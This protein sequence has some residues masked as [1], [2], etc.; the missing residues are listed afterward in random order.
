MAILTSTSTGGNLSSGS[1]WVGGVAPTTG[2]QVV[3]VNGATITVDVSISLGVNA[4][5][6]GHAVE[7]NGA[8][9]TSYGTLVVASGVT[10]TLLG[11]DLGSNT[12]GLVH[13]Y[14]KLTVQ[15]G[16]TIACDPNSDF[17]S[18]L[19]CNGILSA[20]GTSGS[21]CTFTSPATSY[22][23]ANS[24]SGEVYSANW[25]Y[26][27]LTQNLGIR[28]LNRAWIANA[29]GTGLGS[30]GDS[31]LSITSKTGT[32]ASTFTTEVS[33]L[34][35]VTGAGQYFVDY[36]TGVVYF[37]NAACSTTTTGF[38][39]TYKYLT[40]SKGWGIICNSNTDYCSAD[41]EYCDL[42]YMG[43]PNPGGSG[44]Y[45]VANGKLEPAAAIIFHY[46]NSATSAPNRLA[47]V[48]NCT[49]HYCSNGIGVAGCT[50]T[51]GDPI[52][53]E[54]NTFGHLDTQNAQTAG[55]ASQYG[56]ILV[57]GVVDASSYVH[58]INNTG[59]QGYGPVV[60]VRQPDT[61]CLI[62]GNTIQTNLCY[63]S[64]SSTPWSDCTISNNTFNFFGFNLR[65]DLQNNFEPCG[66]SGH[67]IVI[68]NNTYNRPYRWMYVGDYCTID[69]NV[70][71]QYSHHG[72]IAGQAYRVLTGVTVQNNLLVSNAAAGSTGLMCGYNAVLA[73]DGWIV[74][75]NT[76]SGPTGYPAY[77]FGDAADGSVSL[78][79]RCEY[80]NNLAIN[81]QTYYYQRSTDSAAPNRRTV[82]HLLECDNN[83]FHGS[84]T[85]SNFHQGA[86][87]YQSGQKYNFNGSRAI[88]GAAL[89]NPSYTSPPAAQSLVFTYTSSTN[90][91]L[92]WGGGTAAQLYYDGGTVSSS[93][94]NYGGA[95]YPYAALTVSGTS[96]TWSTDRTSANNPI[97]CWLYFGSGPMATAGWGGTGWFRVI[98]CTSSTA[99]SLVPN[100]T[101]LPNAGDAFTLYKGEVAL[102]DSGGTNGVNVGLYWPSMPGSSQTDSGI[103]YTTS[104]LIGTDP[105]LPNGTNYDDAT[106]ADYRPPGTSAAKGA[107]TSTNAPALDFFGTTRPSPPSIGFAEPSG[108]SYTLAAGYGSYVLTG[109]AAQLLAGRVLAAGHGS[110]ALTGE[111]ATLA[112]ARRLSAA[113][114]SDSL[115]G[116]PAT[117]AAA[118]ALAAA[119]GGYL[120]TGQAATLSAGGTA[121]AVYQG[122]DTAT[123]GG[124][125]GAYGADGYDLA[126]IATSLPAYAAGSGQTGGTLYTY[127]AS[128]TDPR[129]VQVPPTGTSRAAYEW[130]NGSSFTYAVNLTDGQPHK[131]S[132]YFYDW[133]NEGRVQTVTVSDTATSAVLDGPRTLSS[134][135][136]GVTLSWRCTGNVTFTITATAINAVLAAVWWD[137]AGYVLTAGTGLYA[138]T[139]EAAA[140]LAARQLAAAQ[141][142]YALTGEAAQLRAARQLSAAQGACVLTG[143]AAALLAGRG[144]SAGNG[145]YLLAGEAAALL[146][147]RRL[148]AAA[149]VLALTGE[150]AA[151]TWSS[152]TAVSSYDVCEAVQAYFQSRSD[153]QARTSDGRLWFVEA[154]E[155][156]VF[157][158]AEYFLV[159]EDD[160][161]VPT[162]AAGFKTMLS[163]VQ[164]SCHDHSAQ[165]AADLCRAFEAAY[166]LAPLEIQ[167]Q[168][169]LHCLPGMRTR[170]KGEGKGPGGQD[171]WMATVD[172]EILW[173]QPVPVLTRS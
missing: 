52:L 70:V 158:F 6:S 147:A 7:V 30:F 105:A 27:D 4:S 149:G 146:A 122:S 65:Y 77:T 2:D 95:A 130:Y 49:L 87:F 79:T 31:S 46:R 19:V 51:S 140:L 99:I 119:Y 15:P 111:A 90:Q 59:T 82:L 141:G 108:T 58:F 94:T 23:W 135:T 63:Q 67:P 117:L 53:I 157:P 60:N 71:T 98:D 48:A 168:T 80:R 36:E 26:Y 123:Q 29:A 25:D 50:G 127:A 150:T 128:S 38:T 14:G 102:L 159:S 97:G 11:Y 106:P 21:H 68:K 121:T 74:Q 171:S 114:G 78:M 153:L 10:L 148:T 61:Y 81:A 172:L 28:Q 129:A 116:E 133:N 18:A 162:P 134:F 20:V 56:G 138:L 120:L 92:A 144:L 86:T 39:T 73:M 34:A 76:F 8:S 166:Q 66:T 143:E 24:A 33:S 32:S 12:C 9:S 169:V 41:L 154:R 35:G 91:T 137:A 142:A 72:L 54:S 42:T 55:T 89:F 1:S 3:V 170:G 5:A 165:G 124:W 44:G 101:A 75:N 113:S 100:T 62:D 96:L 167:G 139:G 45:I 145:S 84:G 131:V 110:Y 57:M 112:A 103:T 64:N 104:D 43:S 22:S 155:G 126:G 151:L 37:Y 156:T 69:S 160:N 125:I 93:S 13:Q 88:P 164:I 161:V 107:G 83:L 47:K 85:N 173:I 16:G 163:T 115:T 136:N 132:L 17:S 40:I 109:E 152:A 118:R